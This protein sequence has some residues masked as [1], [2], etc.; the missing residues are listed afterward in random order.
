M[1]LYIW[2]TGKSF[3]ISLKWDEAPIWSQIIA[4]NEKRFE[5]IMKDYGDNPNTIVKEYPAICEGV[6]QRTLK[7]LNSL[8]DPE[9]DGC[10]TDITWLNME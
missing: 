7:R 9:D 5:E 8:L 10:M 3:T 4:W 1:P 2:H 6:R